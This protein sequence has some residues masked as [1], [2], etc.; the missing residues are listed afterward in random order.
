MGNHFLQ[1]VTD[2]MQP[3]S[4]ISLEFLNYSRVLLSLGIHWIL[5][6]GGGGV[7]FFNLCWECGASEK[8]LTFSLSMMDCNYAA[9]IFN[10][11]GEH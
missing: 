9:I 2:E 4:G 5:S 11:K 6:L 1:D 8:Y 10:I 3:E 7:H